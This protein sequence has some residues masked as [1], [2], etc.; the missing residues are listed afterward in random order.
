[1]GDII[2]GFQQFHCFWSNWRGS[3]YLSAARWRY[4]QMRTDTTLQSDI[5]DLKLIC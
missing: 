3:S 5:A 2:R 4:F 1:M